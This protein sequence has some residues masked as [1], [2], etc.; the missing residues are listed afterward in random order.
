MFSLVEIDEVESNVHTYHKERFS[1][2]DFFC[3][4]FSVW[5]GV[6]QKLERWKCNLFISEL[7]SVWFG[8]ILEIR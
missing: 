2:L 8:S 5:F 6:T 3:Q 1:Q 7:F 4:L